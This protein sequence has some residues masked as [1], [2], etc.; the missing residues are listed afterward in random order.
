MVFENERELETLLYENKSNSSVCGIGI[1][2][3]HTTRQHI[4]L[5]GRKIDLFSLE[6]SQDQFSANVIELKNVP[7]NTDAIAQC[8]AYAVEV[9][10]TFGKGWDVQP[11]IIA[12]AFTASAICLF[13]FM[14]DLRLIAFSFEIDGIKFEEVQRT[15]SP[16]MSLLN[17]E[18][19]ANN[20]E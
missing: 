12:P 19:S 6:N 17:P 5:S 15:P 8:C 4:L 11:I 14:P 3:S 16:Y 9:K 18:N 10:N 1:F 7:A 2:K 20:S 13:E